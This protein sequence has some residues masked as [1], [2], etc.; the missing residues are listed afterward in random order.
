V[1]PW[2]AF[3]AIGVVADRS[4]WEIG[5]MVRPR[6]LLCPQFTEVEW[7]IAPQLSEWAEVATFDAPGVG[8][9]PMPG[10]DAT[11][12]DREMVVQRA[13]QE[14]ESR[15]WDSYFVVGDAWGTATA[16]RV[17]HARPE[18]V[19][20]VALGHAS[21]DYQREGRR[22][23]VNKEVTAAMTQLLRSDYDSFVRYG[24]TQFTQG[25]FDEE[26]SRRI[27]E[28]FPPMETASKV[29][30]SNIDQ[31]EQ[32]GKLL[33]Q[34]D[35]PLLLSKHE[36]CLVFTAE[37]YEDAVRAFPDAR[38]TSVSRASSASEEFAAALKDFCE[39]VLSE[40]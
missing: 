2:I 8:E 16:V 12:L 18:P 23:A 4:L 5:T 36:G 33:E 28:R 31:D 3:A 22:P 21:L 9:E 27:V 32:I 24:M 40:P 26:T 39:G 10:D 20:G 6:L 38:R 15:D 7:T 29:W 19:L 37:G 13:L 1:S 34:L 17:A 11:A 25:A 14:V 35:V 30:E